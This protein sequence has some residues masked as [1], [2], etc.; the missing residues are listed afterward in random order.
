MIIQANLH[1]ESAPNGAALV[2]PT[3]R[4]AQTMERETKKIKHPGG[5][6]TKR[7][8]QVTRQICEAIS[9]NLTDEEVA[10]L[11]GIDAST[12]TRW[13]KE[14]EFCGAIKK[15]QAARLLIRLKR[16]E[17]GE[18][19]WQGTAWALERQDPERFGPP[20]VRLRRND[21]EDPDKLLRE[22][23]DYVGRIEPRIRELTGGWP[24]VALPQSIA[25]R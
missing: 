17:K 1:P 14:S 9:Y 8:A 5:R 25:V 20:A 6:P 24:S 4:T 3:R 18:P 7:T 13:K 22:V 16:I 23:I 11:V 10:A 2:G 21:V 19:G 12:L 15:A